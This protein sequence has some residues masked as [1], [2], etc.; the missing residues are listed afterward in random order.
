MNHGS[1]ERRPSKNAWQPEAFDA[2][3]RAAEQKKLQD[4]EN[5]RREYAEERREAEEKRRLQEKHRRSFSDVM[6]EAEEPPMFDADKERADRDFE[7]QSTAAPTES[8]V[9]LSD[10]LV[11]DMRSPGSRNPKNAWTGGLTAGSSPSASSKAQKDR[12]SR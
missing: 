8:D 6:Q 2:D 11:I 9:A 10:V 3:A 4:L 12:S 7:E 1:E 5:A